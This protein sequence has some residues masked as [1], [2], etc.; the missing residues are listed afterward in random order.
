MILKHTY[1]VG[2]TGHL[3]YT[4]I[5][6]SRCKPYFFYCFTYKLSLR[7]NF[8][9]TCRLATVNCD[10]SRRPCLIW[11]ERVEVRRDYRHRWCRLLK[12]IGGTKIL[13][14]VV[15]IGL[16]DEIVGVSQLLGARPQAAP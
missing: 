1:T 4:L 8:R 9:S 15:S 6:A 11:R 14:E 2:L 13:G 7:T 16:P 12:T 10:S 3:A 5:A